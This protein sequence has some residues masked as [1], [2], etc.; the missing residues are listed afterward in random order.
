MQHRRFS[1]PALRKVETRR[2]P[3]RHFWNGSFFSVAKAELSGCGSTMRGVTQVLALRTQ[4]AGTRP[5]VNKRPKAQLEDVRALLRPLERPRHLSKGARPTPRLQLLVMSSKPSDSPVS[6]R[7]KL[8]GKIHLATYDVQDG[9]VQV[10]Y[11]GRRSVWT[12]IGDARAADVARMILK[13]LLAVLVAAVCISAALADPAAARK[14][15]QQPHAA[16]SAWQALTAGP[17]R[18]LHNLLKAHI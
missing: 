12:E 15:T 9:C 2:R 3:C 5:R 16:Q 11:R 4:G 13:E 10:T 6:I 8:D 18:R 17:V 1:T 14:R 7:L